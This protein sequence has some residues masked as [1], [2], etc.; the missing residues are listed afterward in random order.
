MAKPKWYSPQLSRELISHLYHR[1]EAERIPM[2]VLAN[3]L[4]E[5]ALGGKKQINTRRVTKDQHIIELN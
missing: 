3:R 4:L 2:T 1:A 5:D